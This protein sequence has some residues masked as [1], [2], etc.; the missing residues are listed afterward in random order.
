ML[1]LAEPKNAVLYRLWHLDPSHLPLQQSGRNQ[2]QPVQRRGMITVL[3]QWPCEYCVKEDLK[4][5]FIYSLR[6]VEGEK[7]QV[8]N[9]LKRTLV[10]PAVHGKKCSHSTIFVIFVITLPL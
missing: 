4:Q 6:Q 9:H 5:T 2:S 7:K 8:E 1:V 3:F 10:I